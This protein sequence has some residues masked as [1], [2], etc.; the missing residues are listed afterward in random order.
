MTKRAI[1][2]AGDVA[3]VSLTRGYVATIDMRD[4]GLVEPYTWRA[5][6]QPHTVYAVASLPRSEGKRKVILMHRLLLSAEPGVLVDHQNGDGLFNVRSN[7]RLATSEQNSQNCAPRLDTSSGLK[8]VT[9][10]K[11]CGKWQ[12]QIQA[13]GVVRYLGVFETAAEAHAAYAAA[14]ADLHKEFGRTI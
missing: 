8:G 9:W 4:M 6:V 5:M 7:I 13:Y 14:S 1:L 2:P 12:A 10:N 3:F 11:G